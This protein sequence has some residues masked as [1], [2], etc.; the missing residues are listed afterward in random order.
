MYATWRTRSCYSL[1]WLREKMSQTAQIIIP[2]Q[3]PCSKWDAESVISDRTMRNPTQH[4]VE[5]WVL[6]QMTLY[7]TLVEHLSEQ[8]R[9]AWGN[10]RK[11]FNIQ[12]TTTS[13]TSDDHWGRHTQKVLTQWQ[14]YDAYERQEAANLPTVRTQVGFRNASDLASASDSIYN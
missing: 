8:S 5:T 13:H 14:Q 9:Q 12:L 7:E 6:R 4:S 2:T 3:C 11:Y 1:A 10:S